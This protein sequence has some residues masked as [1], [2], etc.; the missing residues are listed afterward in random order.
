[1]RKDLT[2][3]ASFHLGDVHPA[4]IQALKDKMA[5]KDPSQVHVFQTLEMASIC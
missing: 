3:L 4:K 2:G 5:E 1:M